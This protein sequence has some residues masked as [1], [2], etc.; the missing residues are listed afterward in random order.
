[1][2]YNPI[3]SCKLAWWVTTRERNLAWGINKTE[4]EPTSAFMTPAA[5]STLA[6][7]SAENFRVRIKG[8]KRLTH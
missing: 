4:K 7:A 6:T 3:D 5:S 8:G 2:G 1:L